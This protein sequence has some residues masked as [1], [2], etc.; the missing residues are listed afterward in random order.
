MPDEDRLLPW[1]EQSQAGIIPEAGN[2]N[3]Y[4]TGSWRTFRPVRDMEKCINCLRCFFVC[5]D[6]SILVND[7]KMLVDYD[8]DHCK[9]CGICAEEGPDEAKAIQMVY[10][11]DFAKGGA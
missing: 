3:K 9:G 10:E 5:P 1:Y 4:H 8:L 2:A 6:S 11:G 7:G